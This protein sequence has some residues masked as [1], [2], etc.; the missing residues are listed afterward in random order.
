MAPLTVALEG[1]TDIVVTRSFKAAPAQVW[2]AH[3]EPDLI[4][5]WLLGP[6]GWTMPTCISEPVPGGRIHY[7]WSNGD[8]GFDL[9]GEYLALTPHSRIEHVE[10]MHLPDPTPDTHVV[11]TFTPEGPGTHMMLRMRVTDLATR[12]AMIATGMTGGMET[13]YARLDAMS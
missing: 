2:R 11:T 13:S 7:A 1:D 12:S 3:T 9:T 6:D 10:R 8:N 4:R 5:Q